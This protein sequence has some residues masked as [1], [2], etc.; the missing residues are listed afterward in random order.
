MMGRATTQSS[1]HNGAFRISLPALIE[2]RPLA[3]QF[4][5][6]V[7][8]GFAIPLDIEHAV[9]SAFSEAFNNVAL[10]SYRDRDGDVDVELEIAR[11]RLTV[12]LRDRG[13][14]F[15]PASI[16]APPIEALPERGLGLFIILRAMDEVRWTRENGHNLLT[17]SKKLPL[18]TL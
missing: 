1:G 5:I 6:S 8:R 18:Q 11:G 3:I 14:P 15:A 7:C 9:V 16:G 17:M 2:Q 12:R 13:V 10:H 4:V